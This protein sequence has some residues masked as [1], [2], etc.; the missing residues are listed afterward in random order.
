MDGRKDGRMEGWAN[1]RTNMDKIISLRFRRGIKKL[2]LSFVVLISFC[3]VDFL[4]KENVILFSS[5]ISFSLTQWKVDKFV[6]S[7]LNYL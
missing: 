2:G 3:E 5:V 1:G 4:K 7:Y 6:R